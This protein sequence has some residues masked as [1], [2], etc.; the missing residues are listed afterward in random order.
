MSCLHFRNLPFVSCIWCEIAQK[1][2][3]PEGSAG[4]ENPL[5]PQQMKQFNQAL[6]S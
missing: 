2:E 1:A 5:T 4:P 3:T 6:V